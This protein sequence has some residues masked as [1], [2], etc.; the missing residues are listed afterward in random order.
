MGRLR[1]IL[2]CRRRLL[3]ILLELQLQGF[4]VR[5]KFGKLL[6]LF[7]DQIN[8]LFFGRCFQVSSGYRLIILP[9]FAGFMRPGEWI[10]FD[11]M[12]P[13]RTPGHRLGV[14]HRRS[15]RNGNWRRLRC[16][17]RRFPKRCGCRSKRSGRH[18]IDCLKHLR[19]CNTCWYWTI[20]STSW[21]N[22]LGCS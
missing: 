9:N 8:W 22:A 5:L 15:D 11:Q 3:L 12:V 6:G 21:R 16:T 18:W 13:L 2:R 4:I 10:P 17:R 7:Q 19:I 20:A 14:L 1:R